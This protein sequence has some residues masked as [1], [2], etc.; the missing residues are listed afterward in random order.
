[1]AYGDEDSL[2][3]KRAVGGELMSRPITV[4]LRH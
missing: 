2:S 4:S 3:G 1:M